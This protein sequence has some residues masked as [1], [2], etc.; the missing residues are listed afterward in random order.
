[1]VSGLWLVW[2]ARIELNMIGVCLL[3]C[4]LK[5]LPMEVPSY[6][7]PR[8]PC[9]LTTIKQ[10][11]FDDL[12]QSTSEGSYIDY[13]IPY[14]KWEFLSYLCES[15]ELVLHGSQNSV[16]DKVEPRQASDI[17]TY[18]NQNAIYATTDGIWVIYFAILDR[19]KYPEM[20]LFNSCLQARVSTDQLSE[21]LY[22][23]SISQ[24]VVIKK[25]WCNGVIYILPRQKFIQ[26]APQQIMGV[27]VIFPHWISTSPTKPNAMIKVGPED[28]PFLEQ[29][30]GHNEEKLIELYT[31]NPGV[32]PLEALES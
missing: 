21:P 24:T 27:E 9:E 30:H 1:M 14:P 13:H 17:R 11:T 19:K 23:F 20:S 7:L 25:P 4:M 5:F 26:E 8:P 16:I 22:F 2:L 10:A 18:S 29:I 15:R 12:W 6:L 3:K 32:F 28:F 31:S